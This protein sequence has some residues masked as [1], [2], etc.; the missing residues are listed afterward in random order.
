MNIEL[1]AADIQRN[2]DLNY[3]NGSLATIKRILI[4][5]D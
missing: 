5:N 4:A 1:T 3:K 2:K